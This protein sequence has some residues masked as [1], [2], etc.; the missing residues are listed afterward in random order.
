VCEGVFGGG[1]I[2]GIGRVGFGVMRG[3]VLHSCIWEQNGWFDCH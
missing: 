2:C 3:L 1:L